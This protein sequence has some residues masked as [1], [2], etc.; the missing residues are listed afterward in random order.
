MMKKMKYKMMAFMSKHMLSCEEA[1]FLISRSYEDKLSFK[2][3]FNLK[4]HLLSCYLCRR[5]E[6]QLAELNI[7]VME[8][9]HDCDH[10]GCQHTMP[11]E[12]KVKVTQ[13]VNKEL[14]A[15]S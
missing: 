3:R 14:K 10:V 1:A 15:D 8:Y 2:Q 4:V 13:I 7:A 5:Y 11:H 9:K 6:K 12:A